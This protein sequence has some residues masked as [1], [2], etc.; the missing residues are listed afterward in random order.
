MFS[1]RKG[2]AIER[3]Q[4]SDTLYFLIPGFS[5]LQPWAE[6]SKRLRRN[7]LIPSLALCSNPGLKLANAF[8]VISDSKFGA[9]LQP[10]AE[11][12][13]RL[14]RNLLIPSLALRSNP[15]LN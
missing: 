14:R 2:F 11:I 15:G 3:F 1:T 6:I 13:E 9:A 10:W 4:R 12:S 8:G 5:L 7:L